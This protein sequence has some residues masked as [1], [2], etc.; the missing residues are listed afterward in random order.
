MYPQSSVQ[1]PS[2]I[3][4][5]PNK[6]DLAPSIIFAIAYALTLV[7]FFYRFFK[8]DQRVITIVLGTVPFS[9]ER[10]VVWSVRASLA[11][12]HQPGDVLTKWKIIYLQ[13]SYGLG[14]MS[15][16]TDANGFVRALLVNTTLED[17]KNGIKDQPKNRFWF[18]RFTDFYGLAWLA[19]SVPGSI[20]YSSLSGS[21]NNSHQA[22]K[23]FVLRYEAAAVALA[24]LVFHIACL[25]TF[26]SRIRNVNRGALLWICTFLIITAIV[27]IYRLTVLHYTIPTLN[28]LGS[29]ATTLYPAGSLTSRPAK[30]VFYVLHALPEL[31]A[32]CMIQSVNLRK[33]LNTGPFGDWRAS[34]RRGGIPRLRKDGVEVDGVGV[35]QVGPT[36]WKPPRWV[37]ALKSKKED[38]SSSKDATPLNNMA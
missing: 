5:F 9:V 10:I 12:N 29:S 6:D 2:P 13:I 3:G 34:D 25:L 18:R 8:R 22:H 37:E 30:A 4:G 26:R 24:F 32:A 33:K 17:P 28:A 15:F 1:I 31:I 38:G 20:A 27:P 36:P 14:F 16:C 35:A 23:A 21:V 19:A 11:H 7:P